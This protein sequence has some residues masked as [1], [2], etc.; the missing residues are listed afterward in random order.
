VRNFTIIILAAGAIFGG[1]RTRQAATESAGQGGK[2]LYIKQDQSA[3]SI[4]IFRAG[5]KDA[6]LT[7]VAKADERPYLHPIIAP[8]G[9][10]VITQ[11]RPEHHPHQTGIYWGLKLVNGRDYF[12]KWQGDYWRRVSAS[13]SG[14]KGRQ[15]KWQTVYDLIDEKGS[16]TLTETSNWSLQEK[17]GRYLLDLEWR[18]QARTDITFGKFYVGGLFVRMPWH[19]GTAGEIVNAAGQHNMDIEAQRAIWADV[20]MEIEGR[21][22]WAHVAI[23][24]HPDNKSF[25]IAW[26]TDTQLGLGPSRQILGDWK[27]SKGEIEVVHYRI[28]IYTGDLKPAELTSLWK[29]FVCESSP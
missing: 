24:D 22:D 29:A 14:E 4:A 15:V 18:G 26:R 13:V 27:L 6:I 28:L 10:G 16:T 8:D 19:K 12:M 5:A 2:Y 23:F 21:K 7:Q 9:N 1:C 17:D 20:G 3:G 25:P 11:Y